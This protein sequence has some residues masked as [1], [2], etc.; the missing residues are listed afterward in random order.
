M[1]YRKYARMVVEEFKTVALLDEITVRVV[2]ERNT[3][4]CGSSASCIIREGVAVKGRKL[5]AVLPHRALATIGR[6]VTDVVVNERFAVVGIKLNAQLR[7]PLNCFRGITNKFFEKLSSN[8]VKLS[9]VVPAEKF[10]EVFHPE[11]MV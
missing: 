8:K 3:V 10:D 5:S 1:F 2:S 4:L 11:E 9:F 7:E 6:G